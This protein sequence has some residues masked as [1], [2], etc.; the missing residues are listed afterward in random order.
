MFP[1]PWKHIR[2]L[3]ADVSKVWDAYVYN[4]IYKALET[5]AYTSQ[6][7]TTFPIANFQEHSI[8]QDTLCWRRDLFKDMLLE[9]QNE[10]V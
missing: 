8:P 9:V 2:D 10:T 6:Y 5:H 3:Y 7:L 1:R 4:D